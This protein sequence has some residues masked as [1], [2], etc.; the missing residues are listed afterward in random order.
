MGWKEGEESIGG[1]DDR[2]AALLCALPLLYPYL[3]VYAYAARTRICY[4]YYAIPYLAKTQQHSL[5]AWQLILY[6]WL[7]LLQD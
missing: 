5:V 1:S 2:H 7:A 4:I 6:A 3:Y